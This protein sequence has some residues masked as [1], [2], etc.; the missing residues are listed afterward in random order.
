MERVVVETAEDNV[1]TRTA[2]GTAARRRAK[3]KRQ[4]QQQQLQQTVDDSSSSSSL[5]PHQQQHSHQRVIIVKRLQATSFGLQVLRATYTLVAFLVFGFLVVFCFQIILF[6]VFNM[7]MDGA[8]DSSFA[9]MGALLS[10]PMFLYSIANVMCLGWTFVAETWSGHKLCRHLFQLPPAATEWLCFAVFLGLP[11]ITMAT[12]L[13]AGNNNWWE[14]TAGIWVLGVA[15]FGLA[16][17]LC[18]VI[19]EA[20]VCSKLIRI[21]QDIHNLNHVHLQLHAVHVTQNF[22]F[23]GV[24]YE[25]FLVNGTVRPPLSSRATGYSSSRH[26]CTPL[27]TRMSWYSRLTQWTCCTMLFY[28]R[29]ATPLLWYGGFGLWFC[30]CDDLFQRLRG[31]DFRV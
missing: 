8:E 1:C 7:L 29:L 9:F 5:R 12:T 16:F 25:W 2:G 27:E 30:G 13:F 23:S 4:D 28:E 11:A 31:R 19:Y 15:T 20:Q 14:V 26:P 3:Q 17:A 22:L 10:V 24:R 18:V 6:L 21:Q